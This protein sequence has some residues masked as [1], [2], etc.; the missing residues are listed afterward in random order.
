MRNHRR[1]AAAD[2]LGHADPRIGDLV[3][4]GLAPQLLDDLHD[5]VD[6]RRADGMP[7][8]FRPP[9]VATGIRP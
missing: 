8:A 1:A 2:V 9:I 6:A 7:R 5:L 4:P 3:G